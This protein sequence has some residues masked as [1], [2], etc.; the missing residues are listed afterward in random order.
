MSGRD[1]RGGSTPSSTRALCPRPWRGGGGQDTDRL[2]LREG[3]KGVQLRAGG[4][5]QP[6]QRR[7]LGRQGADESRGVVRRGVPA[8]ARRPRVRAEAWRRRA[9]RLARRNVGGERGWVRELERRCG[10]ERRCL[11]L[12]KR[13]R[14][15]VELGRVK[16]REHLPA[17]R[18]RVQSYL[19]CS[20]PGCG[21]LSPSNALY[22][23][24]NQ[25]DSWE[26]AQRAE[27]A[28]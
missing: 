20:S 19:L 23:S 27:A 15:L 8:P 4:A 17:A 11:V 28:P 9:R 3:R 24:R 16:Q 21:F 5:R 1:A 7:R 22:K 12:W 14:L 25:Q 10:A 13:E 2:G 18:G 26:G 6:L